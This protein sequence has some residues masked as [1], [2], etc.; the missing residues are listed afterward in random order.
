MT[1]SNYKFD[2]KLDLMLERVID[3]P[4]EVIWKAWTTPEYL[5]KWFCPLPWTTIECEIDL[6]RGGI[7]RTVMSSPEGQKFPNLG[8]YLEVIENEKLVWTS[9]LIP[10]FRPATKPISGADM[11]LTAIIS[12]EPQGQ[13]TKYTAIVLHK[14]EE[15]R[16][17]HDKMG[18]HEGWGKALDQLIELSKTIKD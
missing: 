3:I 12:L 6:R 5:K 2:P 17:K 13:A 8:C 14:N 15:D 1:Q 10:N 4:R 16:E 11:F 9:A 18:F 7:F